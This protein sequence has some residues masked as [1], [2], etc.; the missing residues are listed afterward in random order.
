MNSSTSI[1]QGTPNSEMRL[2]ATDSLHITPPKPSEI[3]ATAPEIMQ[4]ELSQRPVRPF[5]TSM[6]STSMLL[7]RE[8]IN[9]T[10]PQAI[11]AAKD[12]PTS[13]RQATFPIGSSMVH[14]HE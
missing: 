9:P 12:S 6:P 5:N 14:I 7:P 3:P 10:M 1:I 2:M 8:T 11:A 13:T 4:M